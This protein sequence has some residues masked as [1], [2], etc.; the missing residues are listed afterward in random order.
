MVKGEHME[1]VNKVVGEVDLEAQHVLAFLVKHVQEVEQA[2][3]HANETASKF[4][5]DLLQKNKL[6]PQIHGVSKDMK[7]FIEIKPS[8]PEK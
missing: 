5:M 8:A 7:T 6:D 1:L 2:A 4:V 3:R